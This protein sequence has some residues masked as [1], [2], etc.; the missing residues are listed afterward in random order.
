MGR[1]LGVS[2]RTFYLTAAGL[3]LA[4]KLA[5]YFFGLPL[6]MRGMGVQIAPNRTLPGYGLRTAG[7]DTAPPPPFPPIDAPRLWLRANYQHADHPTYF[8]PFRHLLNCYQ[9]TRRW[10]CLTVLCQHYRL[11]GYGLFS[12][13]KYVFPFSWLPLP[14]LYLTLQISLAVL[15]AVLVGD[16]LRARHPLLGW[17]GVLTYAAFP[18]L[19]RYEYIIASEGL[20]SSLLILVLWLLWRSQ[21]RHIF[22]LGLAGLIIL[23]LILVRKAHAVLLLPFVGYIFQ[24]NAT[25]RARSQRL[26][27]FLLPLL[28]FEA[29]WLPC[30]YYYRGKPQPLNEVPGPPPAYQLTEWWHLIKLLGQNGEP[31]YWLYYSTYRLPPRLY[32]TSYAAQSEEELYSLLRRYYAGDSSAFYPL[33]K[34]LEN[35][36]EAVRREKPLSWQMET[37]LRAISNFFTSHP[38]EVLRYTAWASAAPSYKWIMG[39]SIALWGFWVVS[40]LIGSFFFLIQIRRYGFLGW[41]GVAAHLSWA[42]YAV[43]LRLDSRYFLQALILFGILGLAFWQHIFVLYGS[44]PMG[45]LRHDATPYLGS[46]L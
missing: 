16:L 29:F 32:T 45:K 23:E 7:L 25:L 18:Y 43:F 36:Y 17:V 11:P 33:L 28:A 21:G 42:A 27:A 5:Y 46:L 37:Y 40:G 2:A 20:S 14:D 12:A 41:L 38:Q 13:L 8:Q 35:W 1:L 34:L 30:T 31:F 39:L 22:W 6:L 4:I 26:G 10:L 19:V 24:Q 15:A 44:A 9:E 3:A